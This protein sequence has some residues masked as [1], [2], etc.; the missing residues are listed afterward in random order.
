MLFVTPAA[1]KTTG[2]ANITA[3]VLAAIRVKTVVRDIME[4]RINVKNITVAVKIR[5]NNMNGMEKRIGLKNI[6][7]RIIPKIPPLRSNNN[8]KILSGKYFCSICKA[9]VSAKNTKLI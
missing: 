6:V 8:D 3:K 5:T 4:E 9:I 2:N 7:M 1:E